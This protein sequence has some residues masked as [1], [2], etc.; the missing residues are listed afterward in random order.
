M[1]Y[2]RPEPW[3]SAHHPLGE[4]RKDMQ[5]SQSTYHRQNTKQAG[6]RFKVVITQVVPIGRNKECRY[7]C[8]Q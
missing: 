5:V 3:K 7:N 4:G 1:P 2:T 6:K 8:G